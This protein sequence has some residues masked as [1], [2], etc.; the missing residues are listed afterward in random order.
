LGTFIHISEDL[1]PPNSVNDAWK[2]GLLQRKCRYQLMTIR[3][4][5]IQG[6]MTPAKE[7]KHFLV[8]DLILDRNL[9][10]TKENA[11]NLFMKYQ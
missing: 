7:H 6:N 11:N 3:N 4:N 1:F 2:T 9:Q 8:T 10:I 5:K